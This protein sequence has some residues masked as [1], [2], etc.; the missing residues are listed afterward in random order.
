[1]YIVTI[2]YIYICHVW[3]MLHSDYLYTCLRDNYSVC[4]F[5]LRPQQN[6][7]NTHTYTYT[8]AR[9]HTHTCSRTRTHT[10]TLSLTHTHIFDIKD[11]HDRTFLIMIMW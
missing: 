4:I 11:N 5:L 8:H 2:Q 10:H 7:H 3:Y 1:M 6:T 9:T